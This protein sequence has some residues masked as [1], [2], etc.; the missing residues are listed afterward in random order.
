MA[1][2][3]NFQKPPTSSISTSTQKFGAS[4]AVHEM[5]IICLH[6]VQFFRPPEQQ[7][8]SWQSTT[9]RTQGRN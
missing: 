4:R 6:L 7:L 1:Q 5:L 8:P 3:Q 2:A 9:A